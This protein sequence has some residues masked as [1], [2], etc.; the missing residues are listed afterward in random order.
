MPALGDRAARAE[1]GPILFV[2]I[3]RLV[4]RDGGVTR[5]FA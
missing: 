3:A 5:R 2:I 1:S 4:R